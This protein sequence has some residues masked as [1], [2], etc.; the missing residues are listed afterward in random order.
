MAR[1][2]QRPR[3]VPQR[4]CVGCR[5]VQGKRELLRVVRTPGGTVAVDPTGKRSGRGAYV[6]ANRL[7]WETALK[8]HSI[9]RALKIELSPEDRE[10]LTAFA[11]TQPVLPVEPVAPDDA[12]PE[13]GS[14]QAHAG[15][16]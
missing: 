7:C 13:Q 16:S 1:P 6:H 10:R 11:Q 15:G 3:R 5:Q 9:D 14:G 4:T 12:E 8:R 2:P